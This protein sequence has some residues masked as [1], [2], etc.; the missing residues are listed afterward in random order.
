M[1]IAKFIFQLFGIN[2]YVVWDE[3]SLQAAVI[4]PGMSSSREEEAIATFIANNDLEVKYLINTHLHI[5]H[6]AGNRFILDHYHVPVL[7]NQADETLGN[8][9]AQQAQMFQLPFNVEDA[10]IDCYVNDGDI[11]KLGENTLKFI[12]TPGHSQ[13]GISV[14]DAQGG[15]VITGDALFAGSIGRTDLPGGDY[16]QLVTSVK[17]KL[18]TLPPDTVV[19]PGHGDPTTIAAELKYNP[20]IR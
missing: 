17:T 7:A 6:A 12:Y 3:T 9:M 15:F 14:Y 8:R 16:E 4:D 13:G 19:Y 1:K 5:D 11:V 18:L 20:F 2:T 10:K